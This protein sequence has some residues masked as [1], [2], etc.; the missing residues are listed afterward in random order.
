VYGVTSPECRYSYPNILILQC[1]Q[2]EGWRHLVHLVL[3]TS[4]HHTSF[5]CPSEGFH[6]EISYIY[7]SYLI[8][9]LYL[10]SYFYFLSRVDCTKEYRQGVISWSLPGMIILTSGEHI[11]CFP[12][13]MRSSEQSVSEHTIIEILTL[14]AIRPQLILSTW[15]TNIFWIWVAQ[16]CRPQPRRSVFSPDNSRRN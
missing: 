14:F 7:Y 12:R 4:S 13:L 9:S 16:H 8:A 15:A 6:Q 11:P 2:T 5:F 10:K 1:K 3:V